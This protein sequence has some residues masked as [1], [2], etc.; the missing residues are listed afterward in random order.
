MRTAPQT[1]EI[2][3]DDEGPGI[4][5]DELAQVFQPFYRVEGSRNRETGGIGL[6]LAIALAVVQAHGGLLTLSNRPEGGLRARI[7][8]PV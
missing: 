4:P 7:E 2:T 1:I 8:L 6:G 5:Q 3:I